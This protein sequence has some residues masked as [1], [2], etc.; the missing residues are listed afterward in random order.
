MRRVASPRRTHDVPTAHRRCRSEG[1]SCAIPRP[2]RVVPE[3]LSG[4]NNWSRSVNS[5]TLRRSCGPMTVRQPG[6][7]YGNWRALEAILGRRRTTESGVLATAL[8]VPV[9]AV[10]QSIE[11]LVDFDGGAGN[12]PRLSCERSEAGASTCA[13]SSMIA[14]VLTRTP[15]T[16]SGRAETLAVI[17]Q[18]PSA[19]RDRL[20]PRERRFRGAHL[21]D[22]DS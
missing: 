12:S 2:S 3:R 20:D 21:L 15:P 6:T 11:R 7:D 14:T 19:G 16:E 8:G 5:P 10:R 4:S 9:A 18:G 1:A 13:P 22:V 17:K